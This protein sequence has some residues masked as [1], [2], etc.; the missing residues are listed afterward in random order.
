MKG[1][2]VPYYKTER[3]V[4]RDISKTQSLEVNLYS[5]CAP[6][7]HRN[8]YKN[9]LTLLFVIVKSEKQLEVHH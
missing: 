6:F 9:T 5:P 2:I 4:Q 3:L 7:V 8:V 1:E